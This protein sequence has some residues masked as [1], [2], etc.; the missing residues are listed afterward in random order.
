MKRHKNLWAKFISMENL[1]LAA[2]K[3]VKSRKNKKDVQLF[4]KDKDNL[5]KQLQDDLINQ[6]FN[7][8]RYKVRTIFEPKKR[9]IYILPLYPDHIV[10]HALINVV[11]PI[12]QS[13]FIHD[14]YAC[15]PGR[16]L[17]SASQRVM[18]FVRKFDFVLQCDVRKFYPSINHEIMMKII[19]RKIGD[20]KI[21]AV[22]R[23]I[24]FSCGGE[25]NLPIGNLTSQWMG[26]VYL[27]EIDHYIKEVLH[28][29]AYLRYCD[30]FLIF[31]ND[32][33]KLHETKQ[34]IETYLLDH[35]N[36]HFSKAS[37]YPTLRGVTFVGYRHFKKFMLLRKCGGKKMLRRIFNIVCHRDCSSKAV[38]Q[39]AAFH[40][41]IK[42]CCGHNFKMF[43]YE[44]TCRTDRSMRRFIRK[45]FFIKL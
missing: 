26:N 31:D 27:N 15:I 25:S 12:W 7:T 36:L 23:N 13:M 45:K 11:G 24:I 33:S 5:L 1:E 6:R 22:L 2:K 32:K 20:K 38:G 28:C 8:S 37:V 30:D 19:K 43:V 44:M 40:G 21:L 42:W 9:D 41:W 16:G 18:E 29:R 17:H 34:K 14:S 10:H 35:L 4:L 3:A 39:L